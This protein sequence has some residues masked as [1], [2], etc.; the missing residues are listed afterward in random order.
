VAVVTKDEDMSDPLYT[1]LSVNSNPSHSS[2]ATT[3]GV[4][5]GADIYVKFMGKYN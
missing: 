4:I 2:F 1:V 5:A 3:L